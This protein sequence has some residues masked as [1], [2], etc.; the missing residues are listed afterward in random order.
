MIKT[1]AIGPDHGLTKSWHFSLQVIKE[2]IQ[3]N[4]LALYSFARKTGTRIGNSL[5]TDS[6]PKAWQIRDRSGATYWRVYDPA[7]NQAHAFS[8][9]AE[10]RMWLEQRYYQR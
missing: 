1:T 5:I 10:V 7:T 8:S 4:L 9:E 6:E 3:K 2:T